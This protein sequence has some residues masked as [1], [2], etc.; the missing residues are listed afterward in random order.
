WAL[1]SLMVSPAT[2]TGPRMY[3]YAP[4]SSQVTSGSADGAMFA[5][6]WS[7]DAQ[8]KFVYCSKTYGVMYA[9]SLAL[10][11][12]TVGVRSRVDSGTGDALGPAVGS[13]IALTEA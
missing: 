4:S 9:S 10:V 2:S 13:P 1:A 7:S 12:A 5:P 11:G 8:S 3:L 6:L